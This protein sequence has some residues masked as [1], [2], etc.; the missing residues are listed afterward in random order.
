MVEG[1]DVLGAEAHH[2]AVDAIE[3][4]S[5]GGVSRIAAQLCRLR[6][7]LF[8]V[9][10]DRRPQ[11]PGQRAEQRQARA[12]EHGE[13]L[14]SPRPGGP[15]TQAARGGD[16]HRDG[17]SEAACGA[18]CRLQQLGGLWPT[19]R[20]QRAGGERADQILMC[21]LGSPKEVTRVE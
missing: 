21:H 4:G 7:G 3:I 1:V 16:E 9:A 18:G 14:A 2:S 8:L 13:H 20:R 11:E 5:P 15:E 10:R 17:P 6:E 12:V 19:Q